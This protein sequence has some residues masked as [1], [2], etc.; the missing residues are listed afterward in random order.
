M[1]SAERRAWVLADPSCLMR[2]VRQHFDDVRQRAHDRPFAGRRWLVERLLGQPFE[3]RDQA[4]GAPLDARNAVFRTHQ[5]SLLRASLK[6]SRP[7]PTLT[8][9]PRMEN[10]E[11]AAL[12]ATLLAAQRLPLAL[13]T[14]QARLSALVADGDELLPY[15]LARS[16]SDPRDRVLDR[17]EL[18][19]LRVLEGGSDLPQLAPLRRECRIFEGL[20]HHA[21]REPAQVAAFGLGAR[22]GGQALRQLGEVGAAL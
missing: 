5:P 8:S 7:R 20:V 2:P 1:G 15:V 9:E 6:P 14:R 18:V 17:D 16:C 10:E 3:A 21:P 19:Q 12:R 22:I 4:L 13:K 11:L